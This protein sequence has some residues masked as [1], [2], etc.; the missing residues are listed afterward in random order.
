MSCR[1]HRINGRS[2]P[3]PC[4]K[5]AKELEQASISRTTCTHFTTTKT[6][7]VVSEPR[8][9]SNSNVPERHDN[10]SALDFKTYGVAPA[11]CLSLAMLSKAPWV[12][13]VLEA[14][15]ETRPAA[16]KAHHQSPTTRRDG[17]PRGR[18][19][20]EETTVDFQINANAA[21]MASRRIP[22]SARD[23]FALEAEGVGGLLLAKAWH[24]VLAELCGLSEVEERRDWDSMVFS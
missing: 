16:D 19:C 14:G 5:C 3:L 23:A 15:V 10:F 21:M 13:D 4:R 2:T 8:L 9:F 1:R 20:L 11:S 22:S 6:G 7:G 12:R 18:V 24:R 17:P